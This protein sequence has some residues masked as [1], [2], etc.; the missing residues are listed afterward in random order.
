MAD[1][2]GGTLM[3]LDPQNSKG[4][5]GLPPGG[6][7]SDHMMYNT[8]PILE[9]HPGEPELIQGLSVFR[10]KETREIFEDLLEL[11]GFLAPYPLRFAYIADS[12]PSDSFTNEYGETFLNKITDVASSGFSQLAQMTGS[13]TGSEA[14][15]DIGGTLSKA[16]E[17]M[18]GPAAYALKGLGYGANLAGN[19]AN[20]IA[21]AFSGT[22]FSNVGHLINKMIAGARID[23]PQVWRNSGFT[24]SYSVTIR[25]YNPRPGNERSTKRWIVGPLAILLCLVV[26][27]S[28]D[29]QTYNWPFF[30][31]ITSSGIWDLDPAVITNLTIIK[32]GDQQSIGWNQRLGIVDVRLDI[33]S[34]YTSMLV[35]EKGLISNRPTVRTYLNALLS[36]KWADGEGEN[37][38]YGTA[39][40]MSGEIPVTTSLPSRR[41]LDPTSEAR[42]IGRP[43]GPT[44]VPPSSPSNIITGLVDRVSLAAQGISDNLVAQGKRIAGALF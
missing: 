43:T 35:E 21:N 34:L 9:I 38:I 33:G 1:M 16:G 5:F 25:L 30:H 13:R 6:H 17:E 32:G 2:I 26:P 39:E 24:P 29:G 40:R 14:L 15:K 11:Q 27:R 41:S 23:F 37:E 18:E 12:F 44:G 36:K 31:R 8:M 19:Y 42:F 20:K 7:V 22:S 3:R 28:D 10:I 4:V